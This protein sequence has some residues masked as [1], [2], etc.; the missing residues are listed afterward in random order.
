VTLPPVL[1]YS[2]FRIF[3]IGYSISSMGSEFTQVAMAWQVYELTSSPLS[4]GL[5]GLARVLPLT[6]MVLFGGV[7]ADAIDRRRLLIAT[8]L[9]Q[10]AVSA[11]LAGVSVSGTVTPQ[12]L[13]AGAA[14]LALC[15]ALDNPTRQSRS[16]PISSRGGVLRV[17]WR[18]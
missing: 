4:V 18:S 10:L 11:L 9:G 13:F 8:Q 14:A 3:G 17:D 15:A 1:R 16:S 12:L 7:L 5:I 2:D 6:A